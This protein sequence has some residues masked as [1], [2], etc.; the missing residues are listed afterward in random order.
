MRIQ[1]TEIDFSNREN[2]ELIAGWEND[3]KIRVLVVPQLPDGNTRPPVTI[4]SVQE[5][6]KRNTPDRLRVDLFIVDAVT[7]EKIGL[8]DFSV[9]HPQVITRGAK[10]AWLGLLIGNPA[11]RGKGVGKLAVAELERR[12]REIG[13]D[14]VEAG[15]FEYNLPSQ[16]LFLSLGYEPI[17]DKGKI[18]FHEGRFWSDLRVGK[19][20]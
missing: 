14:F 1:F 10:V 3:P 8:C 9:N 20:M 16:R 17:G 6:A 4:E 5:R 18:F 13:C 15:A 7:S 11:Y 12:A 2:G 19:R